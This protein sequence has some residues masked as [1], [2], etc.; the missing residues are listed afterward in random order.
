MMLGVEYLALGYLHL[1]A[2]SAPVPMIACIIDETPKIHI[3]ATGMDYVV[4]HSKTTQEITATSKGAYNPYG[5]EVK[6]F[7]DG[8]MRGSIQV[9]TNFEWNIKH[10]PQQDPSTCLSMKS[11]T[12]KIHL[13]PRIFISSE[14]K[15]G[16]CM[17]DAVMGHE[18]KHIYVDRKVVNKYT[19]I[20]VKALDNTFKKIGYAHGPVRQDQQK[21][22]EDQ[23]GGIVTS[24]VGQFAVNMNAE[25]DQLQ[26]GVDTIEEYAR[27]AA[28]CP[29][30]NR[31]RGR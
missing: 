7:T 13:D 16:S 28:I 26:K 15:K 1:A 17:Y 23:I 18:M 27:V 10:I 3:A 25:R 24:V 9:S 4:D 30:E 12:V 22:L 19:T 6:T 31:K 29:E 2:A 14:Y 11:I 20:M 8:L 5:E 21:A